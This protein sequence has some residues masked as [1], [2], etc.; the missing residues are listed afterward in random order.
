MQEPAENKIIHWDLPIHIYLLKYWKIPSPKTWPSLA[1]CWFNLKIT[2]KHVL[3]DLAISSFPSLPP[4]QRFAY[5]QL[6][7]CSLH[8]KWSNTGVFLG[9]RLLSPAPPPIFEGQCLFILLGKE[10]V[11]EECPQDQEHL[12]Q[13][14]A[15]KTRAGLWWAQSAQRDTHILWG[16]FSLFRQDSSCRMFW[17]SQDID[18]SVKFLK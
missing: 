16:D 11:D 9:H 14:N 17:H 13:H 6:F 4:A 12:E 18:T 2:S 10:E 7:L 1:L 5:T 15:C 8:L 3:H